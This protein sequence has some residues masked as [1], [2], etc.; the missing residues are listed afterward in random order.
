MMSGSRRGKVSEF[1]HCIPASS[2][3][4]RDTHDVQ[5]QLRVRLESSTN[6]PHPFTPFSWN[7]NVKIK[8]F[9]F[10]NGKRRYKNC[11]IICQ[12]REI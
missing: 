3:L 1:L 2:S 10:Q 9:A 4:T 8:L 7:D 5:Y 6:E 11:T 12:D